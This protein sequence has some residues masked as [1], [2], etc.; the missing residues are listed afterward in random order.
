MTMSA[1]AMNVLGLLSVSDAAVAIRDT[2]TANY[3]KLQTQLDRVHT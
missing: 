1:A 2:I 3:T